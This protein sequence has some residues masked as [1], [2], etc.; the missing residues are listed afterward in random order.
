MFC[1][2]CF[3]TRHAWGHTWKSTD[4][5]HCCRGAEL[6]C[7]HLRLLH[8]TAVASASLERRTRAAATRTVLKPKPSCGCSLLSDA[9]PAEASGKRREE[10][11][12]LRSRRL[13]AFLSGLSFSARCNPAKVRW[14]VQSED[15]AQSRHRTRTLRASATSLA[16]GIARKTQK[17]EGCGRGR[18]RGPTSISQGAARQ[19]LES[20][21]SVESVESREIPNPPPARSSRPGPAAR[22]EAHGESAQPQGKA[23][24]GRSAWS[25]GSRSRAREASSAA[26]C[27]SVRRRRA[28]WA[29]LAW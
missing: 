15:Q 6:R 22:T 29:L 13:I 9:V 12:R 26:A 27:G 23:E 2:F 3:S 25:S 20:V 8:W 18:G 14:K 24:K 17:A 28:A 19:V 10:S 4:L 11:S 21:E 7:P 5:R 16:P 1:F